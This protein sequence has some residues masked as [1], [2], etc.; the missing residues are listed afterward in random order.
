MATMIGNV[1][2]YLTSPPP[3]KFD[4]SSAFFKELITIMATALI[5][6]VAPHLAP[7]V[8]SGLAIAATTT[9]IGIADGLTAGLLTAAEQGIAVGLGIQSKFSMPTILEVGITSGFAASLDALHLAPTSSLLAKLGPGESKAFLEEAGKQL[10]ATT[11]TVVG[12]QLETLSQTG[13]FDVHELMSSLAV[14]ALNLNIKLPQGGGILGAAGTGAALSLSDSMLSGAITKTKLTSDMVAQALGTGAGTAAGVAVSAHLDQMQTEKLQTEMQAEMKSST[15][16]TQTAKA[17]QTQSDVVGTKPSSTILPASKTPSGSGS[18][19]ESPS[20]KVKSLSEMADEFKFDSDVDTTEHP[21]PGLRAKSSQ[22]A[23][24]DRLSKVGQY[25]Q[26]VKP[27][28]DKWSSLKAETK[29]FMADVADPTPVQSTS[30]FWKGVNLINSVAQSTK[31]YI[32]DGITT[33]LA[34]TGGGLIIEGGVALAAGIGRAA[35]ELA[36]KDLLEGAAGL[37]GKLSKLWKPAETESTISINNQ[38]KLNSFLNS[39][40]KFLGKNYSAIKPPKGPDLI[41]RSQDGL[42]QIRFD[43]TNSHG[44]EPHVNIETFKPRNAYPTDQRLLEMENIH[45]YPKP[46]LTE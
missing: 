39:A 37:A 23:T 12:N 25:Q 3:K 34:M 28:S 38:E 21:L 7:F 30:P 8:L 46:T 26:S 45:V 36:G 5:A 32:A 17:S 1:Y 42:R 13:K 10:L 35:F 9:T 19:S 33:A 44:L 14:Q 4:N 29:E 24:T 20:W 43:I 27:P 31:P 16:Q 15:Q 18:R 40:E 11:Q 6:I 2:P 22:T 41:L